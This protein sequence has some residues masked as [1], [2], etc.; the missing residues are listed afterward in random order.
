MYADSKGI[1]ELDSSLVVSLISCLGYAILGDLSKS[2]RHFLTMCRALCSPSS[3]GLST[4]SAGLM[5]AKSSASVR[6]TSDDACVY[7]SPV[8]VSIHANSTPDGFAVAVSIA[9]RKLC[10]FFSRKPSSTRVPV[11]GCK[12]VAALLARILRL[13]TWR[14]Y[15]YNLSCNAQQSA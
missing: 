5:R 14:Y 12:S 9:R 3:S 1:A 13:H 2:A 10:S 4:T 15:S 8:D 7:S 11:D 6:A